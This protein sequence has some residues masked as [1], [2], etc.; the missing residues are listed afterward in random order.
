MHHST[1]SAKPEI[2]GCIT[3]LGQPG[4]GCWDASQYWVS[5]T[6]QPGDHLEPHSPLPLPTICTTGASGMRT[7]RFP[8]DTHDRG[9]CLTLLVCV[10]L[11]WRISQ[12]AERRQAGR[13]AAS[14]SGLEHA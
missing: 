11:S 9:G 7:L 2:L 3:V 5:Q 6:S 1:G 8:G 10:H 4:Q 14:R 12:E 13:A